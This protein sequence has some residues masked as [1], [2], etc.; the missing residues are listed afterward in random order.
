MPKHISTIEM[1][2]AEFDEAIERASRQ[3][4]EQVVKKLHGLL[5]MQLAGRGIVSRQMVAAAY[6]VSIATVKRWE[7]RH[8]LQHVDGPNRRKVYYHWPDVVVKVVEESA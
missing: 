7:K 5:E 6:D 8:G 4:A 1:T 3:G 2:Q